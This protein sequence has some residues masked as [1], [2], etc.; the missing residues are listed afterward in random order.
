MIVTP[1]FI[2]IFTSSI[3]AYHFWHILLPAVLSYLLQ[4][5]EFTF[6]NDNARPHTARL[7]INYL[8]DCPTLPW[9]AKCPDIAPKLIVTIPTYTRFSLTTENNWARN[10]SG[11]YS[12]TLTVYATP[13]ESLHL[14]RG[15]PY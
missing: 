12:E 8:F 6:Q 13:N 1:L 14:G 9:P 2:I 11:H 3:L 4:H 5:P 7:A 10:S 15:R